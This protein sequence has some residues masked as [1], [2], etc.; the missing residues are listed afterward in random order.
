MTIM[1]KVFIIIQALLVMVY[2]GASS[3]LYQHRRD[4]RGAYLQLKERYFKAASR[5]ALDVKFLERKTVEQD[6]KITEKDRELVSLKTKLDSVLNDYQSK[7]QERIN[8]DSEFVQTKEENTKLSGRIDSLS[9]EIQGLE[10]RQGEL[11]RNLDEL[12]QQRETAEA[13]VARL[14]AQKF[15]QEK[16][17]SELRKEYAE[18]RREL[19][20]KEVLI[21]LA[22][23]K[24][25]NIVNLLD[26][27]P[28]PL[29]RGAVEAVKADIEPALVLIDVGTQDEV[30][31]GYRFA[32][33]RD[34]SYIGR[35]IVERIVNNKA[36]CRVDFTVEGQTVQVGD[37]V[38]TRFP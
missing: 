34:G 11:K 17:L 1:A 26:G 10:T 5:A 20:D 18:T 2:L 35:L 24:G 32:V 25:I 12:R 22:A 27:P 21:A 37:R 31:E 6:Q 8:V 9:T 23:D 29:V 3:A 28:V 15:N 33:Y 13:Q 14:I 36:A 30:E 16:D 7:S 38:T 4:W 19:R